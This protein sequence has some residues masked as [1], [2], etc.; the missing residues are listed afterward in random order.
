MSA[1]SPWQIQRAVLYAIIVRELQTR[2]GG[3]WLGA[4]WFVLEPLAHVLLLLAV[5]GFLHRRV[6]PGMPYPVF[7]VTGL[8]PFFAFRS[9]A[10]RL[11]DAVDANRGLFAYRQVKP[12][13]AFVSR[14]LLELGLYSTVYIVTLALLAWIGF[15][16]LPARPLEMLGILA[17]LIVFGV[18]LGVI[19]AV[20][21]DEVPQLRPFVRMAFF[22]LY[23]LSGVIFPVRAIPPEYI[24]LLLWNPLLHFVELA[25]AFFFERYALLPGIDHGYA[26]AWPIFSLALALALYRA[27]RLRLV[28]VG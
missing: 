15:D 2:F 10:T 20:A 5:F 18:A 17:A 4:I 12:M 3:R 19:F 23:F 21:T 11:M 6:A 7:L 28:A 22:P 8:L 24:P 13:D 14:A 16:A 1:R 25:R 9:V 26:L 27:R